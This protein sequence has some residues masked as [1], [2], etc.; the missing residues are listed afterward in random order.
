M[1][2]SFWSELGH[3]KLNDYKLSEDA[4]SITGECLV[5]EHPA[6]LTPCPL[7]YGGDK[8]ALATLATCMN[9]LHRPQH[10]CALN[11]SRSGLL[12][13]CSQITQR[14]VHHCRVSDSHAA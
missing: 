4:I 9:E 3:R 5:H 2:T 1:D 6:P 10:L 8:Q 12:A 13:T 14:L 7:G 11:D